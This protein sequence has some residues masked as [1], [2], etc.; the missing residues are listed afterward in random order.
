MHTGNHTKPLTFVLHV[1]FNYI[2]S[3]IWAGSLQ[4]LS[5]KAYFVFLFTTIL[6]ENVS[7]F[8]KYYTEIFQKLELLNEG[9]GRVDV[10]S[11]HFYRSVDAIPN[12]GYY[13]HSVTFIRM[14]SQSSLYLVTIWSNIYVQHCIY[15]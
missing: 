3:F 2:W 13:L 12:S 15:R 1:M 14:F 6:V 11:I 10:Y 7:F 9:K 4:Y 8:V 5:V